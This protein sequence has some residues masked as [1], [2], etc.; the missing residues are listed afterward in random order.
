MHSASDG[1]FFTGFI[2]DLTERQET[3]ARLQELQAEL[4]HV[5]RLTAL[6]EMA[7]TLAHELNQPLSAIANYLKGSRRS[8]ST[9]SPMPARQA[10]RRARQG[11]RT[12]AARRRDH[13][14]AARVRRPRRDRAAASRACPS[15]SRKRAPWPWSAPRSTASACA[16]RSI[17]RVDLRPGRPGP[18]PA[19][20]AEPDP[21]RDRGDGGS[22]ER[23]LTIA[24]GADRPATWPRSASPTPARASPGDRRPAL[25]AV[26]HHQARPA[27]AS[28]CRSRGP[29][30]RRMAGGSGRSRTR[31][32][33]RC[34]ASPCAPSTRR[35]LSDGRLSRS[36]M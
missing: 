22:A 25:P 32:A 29:S 4:V 21:Q 7:S 1:R 11:R 12:G 15:W 16:S 17:P 23:E 30:S 24:V 5:S 26:R 33:A 19:G 35:N 14:P 18:D 31:T 36:S 20:G 27:W 34:S 6:G 9:A 28:A 8:C 10:A 2:R 13:P 3:E